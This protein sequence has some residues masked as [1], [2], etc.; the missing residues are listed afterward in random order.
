MGELARADSTSLDSDSESE[1]G[2]DSA[3][4]AEPLPAATRSTVA[5]QRKEER[6]RWKAIIENWGAI[7]R[8][9]LSKLAND[10]AAFKRM[11][12]DVWETD[13]AT[14]PTHEEFPGLFDGAYDHTAEVFCCAEYPVELFL[15]YLPREFWLGVE[16]ET[17]RYYRQKLSARMEAQ[18]RTQTGENRCTLDQII[19]NEKRLHTKF[20]AHDIL[21]CIGPLLVRMLC[22]HT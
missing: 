17:S 5:A 12:D 8:Q 21:Q 7:E 2:D 10:S 9:D 19:E 18:F 13:P 1:S 15:L 16:Q 6:E 4:A 3:D 20:R 14:F 22:L 11:Q